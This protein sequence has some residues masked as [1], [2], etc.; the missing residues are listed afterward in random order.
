MNPEYDR[1][2][3]T[4]ADEASPVVDDRVVIEKTLPVSTL[5]APRQ[6][7]RQLEEVLASTRRYVGANPATAAMIAFAGGA[8]IAELLVVSLRRRSH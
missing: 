4:V 3:P 1:P 6:A 7:P 2:K 5:P 8:L